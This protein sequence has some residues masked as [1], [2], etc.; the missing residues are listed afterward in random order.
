MFLGQLT[1]GARQAKNAPRLLHFQNTNFLE[2]FPKPVGPSPHL[3]S[4]VHL[5]R[6]MSILAKEIE[7]SRQKTMATNISHKVKEYHPPPLFLG[8]IPL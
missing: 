7:F 5:G 8:K 6:K 4:L 3:P 2:I 1:M